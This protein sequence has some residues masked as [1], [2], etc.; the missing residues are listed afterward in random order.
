MLPEYT[1]RRATVQA[2]PTGATKGETSNAPV[3][4]LLVISYI[5]EMLL[6]STHWHK[7]IRYIVG[8]NHL[9]IDVHRVHRRAERDGA[10]VGARALTA[11][12]RDDAHL[13]R[14]TSS[15]GAG[16]DPALVIACRPANGAAS[17]IFYFKRNGAAA[18]SLYYERYVGACAQPRRNQDGVVVC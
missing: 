12:I 5:V 18:A 13:A 15:A 8:D 11:G 6:T 3:S 1:R 9:Y 4:P 2:P 14:R 10:G 17:Q 16:R 7:Y